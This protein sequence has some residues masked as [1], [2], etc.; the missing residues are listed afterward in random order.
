MSTTRD[1]RGARRGQAGA[2]AM[3]RALADETRLRMLRLLIEERTLCVCEVMAAL[4][5]SQTRASR[6]LTM[7]CAAGLL[8]GVRQGRWRHY[9]VTRNPE[10]RPL[11]ALV[12]RR[13]PQVAVRKRVKCEE[14]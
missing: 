5:I 10:L 12:R 7:L 2:A 1:S 6:N 14:R 4:G 11:F 13:G 8:R 9:S 3:F